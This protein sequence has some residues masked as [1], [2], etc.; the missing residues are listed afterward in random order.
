MTA[1]AGIRAAHLTATNAAICGDGTTGGEL[2]SQQRRDIYWRV[3]SSELAKAKAAE[4]AQ[5]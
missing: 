1:G 5:A 2:S 4:E 3:L